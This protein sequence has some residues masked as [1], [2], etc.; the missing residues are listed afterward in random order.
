MLKESMICRSDLTESTV[1]RVEAT[2]A[3]EELRAG[4]KCLLNTEREAIMDCECNY[5]INYWV[6]VTRNSELNQ[7]QWIVGSNTPGFGQLLTS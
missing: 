7:R 2:L 5:D 3:R 4:S 1:V 6:I